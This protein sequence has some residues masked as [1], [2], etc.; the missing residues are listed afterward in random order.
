MG[1]AAVEG[2]RSVSIFKRIFDIARAE[3]NAQT[4][5]LTNGPQAKT[6]RREQP[7]Q[8]SNQGSQ[9]QEQY[10]YEPPPQE[11]SGPS[12]LERAYAALEVPYNSDFK[13]VKK[14]WRQQLR[15]YHPDKHAGDAAK[16]QTAHE[17]SQQI[18]DAYE[19]I[20]KHLGE[21]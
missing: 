12:E 8:S 11:D 20:K 13:T 15:K 19:M 7:R 3:I 5:K 6:T 18:N 16:Q 21:K 1:L 2:V 4:E 10:S 17:I 9:Q 14:A